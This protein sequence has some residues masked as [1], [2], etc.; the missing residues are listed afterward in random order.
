MNKMKLATRRTPVHSGRYSTLKPPYL[1]S[2]DIIPQYDK[3]GPNR[4]QT[5]YPRLFI[6]IFFRR[7]KY[8]CRWHVHIIVSHSRPLTVQGNIDISRWLYSNTIIIYTISRLLSCK[9]SLYLILK[10]SSLKLY[11][12]YSYT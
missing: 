8:F 9:S 7:Y 11:I 1:S 10:I 5:L 4:L 3:I 6:V 12:S 2:K